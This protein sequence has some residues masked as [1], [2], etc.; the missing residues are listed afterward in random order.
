M[1]CMHGAIIDKMK[2]KRLSILVDAKMIIIKL[3]DIKLS[4]GSERCS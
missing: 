1:Q 2:D 3:E 4:I